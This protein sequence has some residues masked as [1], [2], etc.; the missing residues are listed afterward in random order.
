MINDGI[1]PNDVTFS[2]V[3]KACAQAVDVAGAE[4]WL[5]NILRYCTR[6]NSHIIF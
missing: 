1:T 3:I 5:R 6:I 4:K 2:S